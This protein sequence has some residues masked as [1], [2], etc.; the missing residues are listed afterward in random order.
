MISHIVIFLVGVYIVSAIGWCGYLWRMLYNSINDAP[1][2]HYI[3]C[4]LLALVPVINTLFF[5][6]HLYEDHNR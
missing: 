3:L 5:L 2:S 4:A 6:I 1:V